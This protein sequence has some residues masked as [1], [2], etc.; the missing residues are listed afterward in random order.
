MSEPVCF[1]WSTP[2]IRSF[3]WEDGCLDL[4][5]RLFLGSIN[6]EELEEIEVETE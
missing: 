4:L 3:T 5:D 2:E 6:D 1:T